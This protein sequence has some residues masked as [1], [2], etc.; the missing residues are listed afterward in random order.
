MKYPNGIPDLIMAALL[1][2]ADSA[3]AAELEFEPLTIER[4]H[5]VTVNAASDRVCELLLPDNDEPWHNRR[6]NR[7]LF[8][9]SPGDDAGS[10]SLMASHGRGVFVV[11]ADVQSDPW[12][13]RKVQVY[14]GIELL[15]SELRCEAAGHATDVTVTWKVMGLSTDGNEAVDAFMSGQQGQT[16][17][18]QVDAIVP[19]I[20]AYLKGE[21]G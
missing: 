21:H 2:F 5:S 14:P 16:F 6:P 15:I 8:S 7:Q 11:L 3:I 18:G 19:A 13:V 9:L 17:E 10:V 20:E 1:V 12:L 4:S